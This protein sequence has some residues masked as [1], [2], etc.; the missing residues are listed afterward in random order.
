[1][2]RRGYMAKGDDLEKRLQ[3]VDRLRERGVITEEEHQARRAALMT[4]QPVIV[5]KKGGGFFKIAGLG[6]GG[7]ILLVVVIVVAVAATGGGDDDKSTAGTPGTSS[8]D[9]HVP[10]AVGSKG[11]VAPERHRNKKMQ[12]TILE[13]T[14][15][16]V[17]TNQFTQPSAGKKFWGARVEIENV[18]TEEITN[19]QFR[20]RDSKDGEHEVSISGAIATGQG[21]QSF[22]SLTP[23]GKV[24]GYVVF[25][26]DADASPKWLRAD[27]N[28]LLKNDLYFDAP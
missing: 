24:A 15:A 9:V 7:L 16:I 12:V 22:V 5:Q 1:M 26:I 21:L 14:D 28:F 20:L 11:V 23:G 6:C 19:P 10:L 3:D 13:I 18:G 25:E 27:P 17:S 8:G 4:S 2:A